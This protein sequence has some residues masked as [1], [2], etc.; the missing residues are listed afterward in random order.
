MGSLT[1]TTLNGR[2]LGILLVPLLVACT[3]IQ[4]DSAPLDRFKAGNFQSYSWRTPALKTSTGDTDAL[5]IIDPALRAAVD[6]DLSAKGYRQVAADGDF[7][8]DYQFRAALAQ[9]E[10]NSTAR[11]ADNTSPYVDPNVVVN[12]QVNQALLDNAYALSGPKAINSIVIQFS[13]GD[14]QRLLWTT[15][16]NKMVENVNRDNV[17]KMTKNV[18]TAVSRAFSRLPQARNN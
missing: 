8:I 18:N 14:K 17:E 11:E 12:R 4:I 2:W 13:S 3:G 10:L 15:A 16:I 9:G 5:S 6:R 7:I 1:V